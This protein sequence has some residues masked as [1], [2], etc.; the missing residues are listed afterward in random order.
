M[1]VAF[2]LVRYPTS[3]SNIVFYCTDLFRSA[4]EQ[5]RRRTQKE[6][7]HREDTTLHAFHDEFKDKVRTALSFSQDIASANCLQIYFV[8]KA[9]A[10]VM[11]NFVDRLKPL[12]D[13]QKAPV[14]FLAEHTPVFRDSMRSGLADIFSYVN[15]ISNR[16]R[17]LCCGEDDDQKRDG[18][19]KDREETSGDESD[20]PPPILLLCT[21]VC[22][23]CTSAPFIELFELCWCVAI[24]SDT[25]NYLLFHQSW[26]KHCC[27]WKRASCLL[28]LVVSRKL[29]NLCHTMHQARVT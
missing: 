24:L 26:P 27:T 5:L 3:I 12:F 20:A 9:T 4:A 21:F 17:C 16:Y 18:N 29:R 23:F 19:N 28:S 25:F 7:D 15:D 6:H 2:A 11:N 8:N 13:C 22:T 10:I 1:A 14:R